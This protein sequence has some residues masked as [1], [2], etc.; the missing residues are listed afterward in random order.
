[1]P[2]D[3]DRKN[4]ATICVW[5][6]GGA[7]FVATDWPTGESSSSASVKTSR[8][9]T[10]ATSGVPFSPVPTKGRNSRN[11]MPM[12]PVPSANFVGVEGWRAPSF[13]HIAAKTPDSTMMN[14]GLID[15]IHET[16]I[17]QSKND[18]S[19]RWSEYTVTTVNCCWYSDQ[20]TALAMNSGMKATTRDRSSAV[21]P[22]DRITTK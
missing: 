3:T 1:M 6:F 13:V 5:N 7:S 15:W 22:L 17:V 9:A 12:I 16:G 14:T 10:R 2:S 19:K 11:A 4:S 21:S 18:R 20:N 8:I